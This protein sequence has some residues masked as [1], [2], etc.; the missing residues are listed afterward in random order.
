ML[1]RMRDRMTYAN[2]VATLA[3]FVALGG[4]SYAAL[5]LPKRSVGTQQLRT[6]A[7]ASR[8][9]ADRSLELRDISRATRASLSGKQ[10]VTGPQGPAGPAGASAVRYFAAVTASGAFTRGN[11]TNGGRKIGR[12][13][14]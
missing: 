1:R 10:G 8:A 12:A 14:V 6:G 5:T 4:S 13:H 2:V 3:L 7:V 11:A 9:V